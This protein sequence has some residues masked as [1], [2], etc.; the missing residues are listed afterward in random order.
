MSQEYFGVSGG[1]DFN[2]VI[3]RLTKR[4]VD[5]YPERPLRLVA[6]IFGRPS[7]SL[8]KE[9]FTRDEL[10]YWNA[11][12]G[13][14]VEFFCIG[15]YPGQYIPVG[16]DGF[17]A[18][19][20]DSTVKEFQAETSWRY[21]GDT[22][23]VFANAYFDPNTRIA[24]L[25]FETIMILPLRKALDKKVFES[26]PVFL[27]TVIRAAEEGY[28]NNP[29]ADLSDSLGRKLAFVSVTEIL[30]GLLPTAIKESIEKLL[31]CYTRDGRK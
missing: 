8:V 3:R 16:T 29:T 30:L 27:E 4:L 13:N 17:D 22:D 28:S 7:S 6:L 24:R 20:F 19:A 14:Y 10:N 5:S 18:D 26:V 9:A 12:S 1:A 11:R 2:D 21:S 15:F 23:V 25:D 31:V